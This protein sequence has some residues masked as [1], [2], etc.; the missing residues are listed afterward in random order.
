MRRCLV[1]R[2]GGGSQRSKTSASLDLGLDFAKMDFAKVAKAT[3][4][5]ASHEADMKADTLRGVL[6]ELDSLQGS[7]KPPLSSAAGLSADPLSAVVASLSERTTHQPAKLSSRSGSFAEFPHKQ[8]KSLKETLQDFAMSGRWDKAVEYYRKALQDSCYAVQATE[9]HEQQR[10]VANS[11]SS[12]VVEAN[13]PKYCDDPSTRARVYEP[14]FAH[15]GI[16]RWS[17]NH[18]RLVLQLLLAAEAT[19]AFSSVWE[20]FVA[21]KAPQHKFDAF[22]CNGLLPLAAGRAPRDQVQYV[23]I[24]STRRTETKEE[25]EASLASWKSAKR[26]FILQL[27]E[28]AELEKWSLKEGAARAVQTAR[29]AQRI[30]D[31][32]D[33]HP[34]STASPAGAPE[35]EELTLFRANQMLEAAADEAAAQHVLAQVQANGWAWNE[36]TYYVMLKR[37]RIALQAQR[38]AVAAPKATDPATSATHE[39]PL[40]LFRSLRA[41]YPDTY[42]APNVVNEVLFHLKGRKHLDD[43]LHEVVASM[44]SRGSPVTLDERCGPKLLDD[45][46]RQGS[47]SALIE[48]GAQPNGK[49]FESLIRHSLHMG[50]VRD[51]WFWFG[52]MRRLRVRG[53]SVA[54]HTMID[55]ASSAASIQLRGSG[56]GKDVLLVYEAM[57]DVGFD[58]T[59]IGTTVNLINAWSSKQIAASRRRHGR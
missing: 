27:G 59:S 13:P 26:K 57:K 46:S 18:L 48:W 40:K 31:G 15:V 12:E 50:R 32:M 20:D 22:I 16:G 45:R 34:L 54:Y 17:G 9:H 58:V 5:A 36:R 24:Q 21:T 4:R 47:T 1:V 56:S 51:T 52:E 3:H 39:E 8:R 14:A 7:L 38:D 42:P 19:D 6:T 53:T 25:R 30:V 41:A 29:A 33:P 10:R 23:S 35:R 43:T 49:T 44:V 55:V 37:Y 11:E 2:I 28:I